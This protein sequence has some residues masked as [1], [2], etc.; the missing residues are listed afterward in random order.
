MR[1]RSLGIILAILVCL[2]FSLSLA[3]AQKSSELKPYASRQLRVGDKLFDVAMAITPEE[4][5]KGLGG[6]R[7]LMYNEG[8]YFPLTRRGSVSFWMKGMYIP[9]D[10][11]WI[12][13]SRV[14]GITSNVPAWKQETP[15]ESLPSY[16][17]PVRAPDAV[18]EIQANRAANYGIKVGDEVRW[19]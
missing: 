10:I 12:K 9:I 17:S 3:V 7:R 19:E 15:D 18:L 8:M 6:V 1:S 5:E 4:Q 14:A 16:S 2:T 13:N 11:I